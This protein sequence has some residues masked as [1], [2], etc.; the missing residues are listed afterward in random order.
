MSNCSDLQVGKKPA[1]KQTD[2][3]KRGVDTSDV[4][5]RS[6]I[7]D[8]EKKE[9]NK[10][11]RTQ[12]QN[13]KEEEHQEFMRRWLQGD[14]HPRSFQVRSEKA[15]E[16]EEIIHKRAIAPKKSFK[17]NDLDA[18]QERRNERDHSHPHGDESD[19]NEN[20]DDDDDQDDK[21]SCDGSDQFNDHCRNR[22][23]RDRNV[24]RLNEQD[25]PETLPKARSKDNSFKSDNDDCSD[26]SDANKDYCKRLRGQG[27]LYAKQNKEASLQKRSLV[28]KREKEEGIVD[29]RD[30]Y[31]DKYSVKSY[32]SRD[33]K[34]SRD[35]YRPRRNRMQRRGATSIVSED[36]L[37]KRGHYRSKDMGSVDS[38]NSQKSRNS[39]RNYRREAKGTGEEAAMVKR[40]NNEESGKQISLERRSNHRGRGR[41]Y[42]PDNS[43]RGIQEDEA[44]LVEKRSNHRGRGRSYS[45]HS[46]RGVD[47][48]VGDLLEKRSNHRGGRGRSYSP[49]SRRGLE[50]H[51]AN[52]IEKRSSHRGGWR[53]YRS[54]S[55]SRREVKDDVEVGILK[56]GLAPRDLVGLYDDV[57]TVRSALSEQ[58]DIFE[59]GQDSFN[60]LLGKREVYNSTMASEEIV[61][62]PTKMLVAHDEAAEKLSKRDCEWTSIVLTNCS[63]ANLELFPVATSIWRLSVAPLIQR[64]T[65]SAT[66]FKR[67]VA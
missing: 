62:A 40:S 16:E 66:V 41:S 1:E 57:M 46:R 67:D 59:R 6:A 13:K 18:R 35:S 37:E 36:L 53:G 7:V 4:G 58:G 60:E 26:A 33:S 2:L 42:S 56:R 47:D 49:K 30:R 15:V 23:L 22:A 63:I 43:R 64:R 44:D 11:A 38:F 12:I 14:E 5:D 8:R 3:T 45:P 54:H 10:D 25:E 9:L 21:F 32:Q 50:E 34:N 20:D 51:D 19:D 31:S 61:K 39:S 48:Q 17:Y 65:T 29:K 27:R 52:M 28:A 55:R 24:Q